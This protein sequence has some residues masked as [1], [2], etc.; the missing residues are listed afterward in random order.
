MDK[1]S[2]HNARKMFHL[3]GFIVCMTLLYNGILPVFK[4][5]STEAVSKEYRDF[6]RGTFDVILLGSSV[7]MNDVYPLQLYDEYGIS[8][9]NLGSGNQ[10]LPMTYYLVE[11][12]L[13]EQD[14]KLVVIDVLTCWDNNAMCSDG[15]THFV[16]DAMRFPEKAELIFDIIPREKQMDFFLRWGRIIQDGSPYLKRIL[17]KLRQAG[18][19]LMARRYGM[20]GN[21]SKRWGNNNTE[22][23]TAGNP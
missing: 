6:E 5:K 14:P 1:T 21:R 22:G 19:E 12:T 15:I 4:D 8:A 7:M 18:W 11:E 17:K 2:V 10:R 9:Y 3:A 23:R 16:T 13:K 20:G